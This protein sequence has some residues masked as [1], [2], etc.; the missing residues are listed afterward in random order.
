MSHDDPLDDTVRRAPLRGPRAPA[1]ADRWQLVVVADG[2]FRTYKLTSGQP[3]TIGRAPECEVRLD[4]PSI[5][6]RHAQLTVGD[7]ISLVDL[8]SANGTRVA[9]HPLTPRSPFSV[10]LGVSVELGA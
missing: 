2:N 5:S 6:R 1:S 10:G 9:G 8:D 7:E 4:H 3:I